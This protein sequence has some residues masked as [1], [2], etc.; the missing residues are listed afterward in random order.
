MLEGTITKSV[1]VQDQ[2]TGKTVLMG[3]AEYY[4]TSVNFKVIYDWDNL[5]Y[6]GFCTDLREALARDLDIQVKQMDI[7]EHKLLAKM[8]DYALWSKS[9]E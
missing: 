7:K 3:V 1:I 5:D 8:K 9:K 6:E 4:D 2:K